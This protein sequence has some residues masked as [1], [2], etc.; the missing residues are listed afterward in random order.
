MCILSTFEKMVNISTKLS[1]LLVE[2]MNIIKSNLSV[3]D[4]ISS[5]GTEGDSE[6]SVKDIPESIQLRVVEV[7]MLILQLLSTK[8]ESAREAITIK[9]NATSYLDILTQWAVDLPGYKKIPLGEDLIPYLQQAQ[10]QLENYQETE[11]LLKLH[12]CKRTIFE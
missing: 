5:D 8:C 12:L 11:L 1:E 9:E 2:R 10:T 3:G 4:G 6:N 7:F